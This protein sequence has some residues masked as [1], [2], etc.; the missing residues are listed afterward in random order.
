MQGEQQGTS[1]ISK[2]LE[3]IKKAA[4]DGADIVRR[5][6]EFA[7]TK[8]ERTH[9]PIDLNQLILEIKELTKP[10]WKDEAQ[11]KGIKIEFKTQLEDIP[12]IGGISSELKEV[13]TNLIFNAVDALPQGGTITI[14]SHL[15]KDDSLV[16]VQVKDTG[17][18]MSAA[19]RLKAFEPFFTTKGPGNSGL[20]LSMSYGIITAHGGNIAIESQEGQGTTFTIHLPITTCRQQEVEDVTTIS[21][22]AGE[23]ILIIE[24]E[25]EIGMMLSEILDSVG[26]Q[27][28]W[29][30]S[31]QEGLE[32]FSHYRYDLVITDLGMPE[33][34]GWKVAQKIKELSPQVPVILVTG[35][36][37]EMDEQELKENG[38]DLVVHKPWEM[39]KIL[40]LIKGILTPS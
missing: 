31:G 8:K 32:L 18:G 5:I 21:S 25:E 34:S 22:F 27:A 29:A 13:F 9:L 11:Q 33:I 2:G 24:D 4:L 23:R 14:S 20:G 19:T 30:K 36:N 12:S 10:R 39:N 40:Q 37:I 6:Q 1:A 15:V 38:V 3:V 17:I 7:R 26:C 28:T 35:W 16:E